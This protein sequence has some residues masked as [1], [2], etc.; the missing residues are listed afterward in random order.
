MRRSRRSL[1]RAGLTECR[2]SRPDN[3]IEQDSAQYRVELE[4]AFKDQYETYGTSRISCSRIFFEFVY[5][6]HGCTSSAVLM[7][8]SRDPLLVFSRLVLQTHISTKSI[9]ALSSPIPA[10]CL[11]KYCMAGSQSHTRSVSHNIRPN[12]SDNDSVIGSI[13]DVGPV[14]E[15]HTRWQN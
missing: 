6:S 3:A 5:D 10:H 14:V 12:E 8:G 7:I 1:S 11:Q 2:L 9:N 15:F 13:V 4:L